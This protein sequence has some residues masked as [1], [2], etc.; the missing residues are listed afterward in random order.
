MELCK[1]EEAEK[2]LVSIMLNHPEDSLLK[3]TDMAFNVADIFNMRLRVIA[4][5]IL[6][7][8]GQGKASD[9]RVIYEMVRQKTPLEFHELSEL[10]TVCPILGAITE[11]IELTRVAAKR[12][13]MQM[14]LHN[15]LT[16]VKTED[17]AT[18]LPSLVAVTEGIQNE[19]E[20]PKV[21]SFRDQLMDASTRY[22]TGDDN[23]M[24]VRTG[25]HELDNIIPMRYSD[26]IVIGGETKAG[27][28]TLA[29]N[30]VSFIQNEISKSN[31]TQN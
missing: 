20:P 14:V 18:F 29:L 5:V 23:T 7:Q 3:I 4:E 17:L 9:I 10:Y 21:K 24:R 26:L 16:E 12:R 15:A 30:I 28:T 27:K 25:Y 11:F 2:G 6:Q 13:A 31:T 1:A 8:V 22:E 19:I